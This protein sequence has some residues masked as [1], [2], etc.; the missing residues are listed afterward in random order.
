[1]TSVTM[2]T[3]DSAALHTTKTNNRNVKET[4]AYPAAPA[5]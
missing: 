4:Q 1:M 3:N 5:V 2:V